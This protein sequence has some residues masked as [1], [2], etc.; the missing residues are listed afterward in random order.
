ME[1]TKE[2]VSDWAVEGLNKHGREDTLAQGKEGGGQ[3]S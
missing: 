1:D 3:S 2:A